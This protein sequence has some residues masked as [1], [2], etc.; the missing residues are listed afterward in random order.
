M[1]L[2]E[3]EAKFAYTSFNSGAIIALSVLHYWA[4]I[5]NIHMLYIMYIML[6]YKYII[7][8]HLYIMIIS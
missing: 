3:N 7:C 5:K 4:D 1:R 8:T 2:A 6:S